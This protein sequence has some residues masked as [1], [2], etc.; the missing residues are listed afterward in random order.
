MRLAFG[1]LLSLAVLFPLGAHAQKEKCPAGCFCLNDG[2]YE[3]RGFYALK[4]GPI[5]SESSA[6]IFPSNYIN[7]FYCEVVEI[8]NDTKE[9]LPGISKPNVDTYYYLSEFSEFYT[10]SLGGYG[11]KNGD[12]L[13][14]N[15]CKLHDDAGQLRKADSIFQCP[16]HFPHSAE[17]SKSLGDCFKYDING[18][19]IYYGSEQKIVCNEG[20]YLPVGATSCKSCDAS[21]NQVCPGGRFEKSEIKNQGLK[22]NCNPG[23]FL[24]ANATECSTCETEYYQCM[25][26]TY[27]ASLMQDQGRTPIQNNGYIPGGDRPFIVCQPG[28]YV[29]A[30][31][32]TCTACTGD[33]ICLGGIFYAD[34]QY[35]TDRGATPCNYGK[36][37]ATHTECINQTTKPSVA[38]KNTNITASKNIVTTSYPISPTVFDKSTNHTETIEKGDTVSPPAANTSNTSIST[39]KPSTISKGFDWAT[40]NNTTLFTTST[41]KNA[42]P[43]KSRTGI[44]TQARTVSKETKRDISDNTTHKSR[45]AIT[46]PKVFR[47]TS[48]KNTNRSVSNTVSRRTE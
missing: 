45:Q 19:K 24:P 22:V 11:L 12:F 1:I 20:H 36:A 35:N 16:Y 25:G 32:T 13:Y 30:N 47:P 3:R 26:G 8:I 15:A 7:Q 46:N 42:V 17:G 28:F 10:G 18:N 40:L 2:E 31:T 29:P 9:G 6:T 23:E 4:E 34:I 5:C 27:D 21:K 39:P 14:F 44:N 37:N 43:V 48:G 38:L 41:S 33:N